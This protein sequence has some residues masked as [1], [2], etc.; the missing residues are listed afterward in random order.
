MEAKT[1]ILTKPK[2]WRR[3]VR[4]HVLNQNKKPEALLLPFTTENIVPS[5]QRNTRGHQ[6]PAE[7][8]TSDK[9]I[10]DALYRDP[11]YGKDF[12]EKGDA[13][14]KKKQ[15]S[16]IITETDSKIIALRNLFK[17]INLPFDE[18]LTYDVLKA[19]YDIQ[20]DALGGKAASK[21]EPLQIPHVPIDVK[22]SI[23][24][25]VNAA[26]QMYEEI[27]GEPIPAIV[28]NDLGF[29]D[30]LN[31]PDFDAQKYIEEKILAANKPEAENAE[32]PEEVK[33]DANVP[34]ADDKDTLHKKY[35]EKTGKNVP[36]PK[37]NDLAW[38][39]AKLE[40]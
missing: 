12:I 3:E 15:P 6:V 31:N 5:K 38:I 11:A 28:E 14:G 2:T 23:E 29:L 24:Q 30:A 34:A 9:I 40:A 8:T 33:K 16:L 27:Y 37:V 25:G 17:L 4:V 39:K 13:E 1:F 10:I 18:T 22:A 35:F 7:Y 26:R 20:M 21:S 19:Q 36:T 32:K